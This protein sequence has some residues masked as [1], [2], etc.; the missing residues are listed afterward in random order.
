MAIFLKNLTKNILAR[1]ANS[2][3]S[4]CDSLFGWHSTHLTLPSWSCLVACLFQVQAVI[5][6]W[7]AGLALCTWLCS[8]LA[9]VMQVAQE[10]AGS[11]HVFGGGAIEISKKKW[12]EPKKKKAFMIA[13][14]GKFKS[15]FTFVRLLRGTYSFVWAAAHSSA[16]PQHILAGGAGCKEH[17]KSMALPP[18]LGSCDLLLLQGLI[19]AAWPVRGPLS[20][21]ATTS[22]LSSHLLHS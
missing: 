16:K 15:K 17:P 11:G 5:S 9:D 2:A 4:R 20:K 7:H 12:N 8:L 19:W 14:A 10:A 6:Q 21:V 18:Y 22:A 13:E 1:K 3:L